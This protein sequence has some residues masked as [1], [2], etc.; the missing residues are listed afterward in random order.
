RGR[1]MASVSPQNV[2]ISKCV[3]SASVRYKHHA[4]RDPPHTSVPRCPGAARSDTIAIAEAS[5]YNTQ[6]TTVQTLASTNGATIGYQTVGSGPSVIVIPGA[7]SIAA[8][9]ETFA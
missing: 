6:M 1:L 7:L 2:S 5:T 3:K 9:F 8:D 4:A